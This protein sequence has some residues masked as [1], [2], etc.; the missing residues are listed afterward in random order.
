MALSPLDRPL[1]ELATNDTARYVVPSQT[2]QPHQWAWDSC[3]HAIILAY[4][5]PE[6][7]ARELES[8]LESQWDDGRVPHM[9][10]NPAVPANK[11]RP[12]AEDWGTG[13]PTSGIAAPPL[14]ATAAKVI[15][16]RTGDLEFLKRVYPRIGAYHRWLKGTRD[17]KERG[18]VGIVHPWESAMDDSPAWDG[19]RDEFLR[20]RGGEAAALPR[21]DLRGVPN[22]QRPGDEDHRFYG[23]LI[24]ELQNTGWDG[25]RMAEGSPF[26]V[27][28]VLF[29]SL[30]AKAN[31]DLSQIAWLLGE[32]GDSSQYRFYSS[33]VRQAIRESMW[34]AEARFFFPIDLRRWESIRVKS[35][36]GFLPLYAQAASAP[37]ASLLVE[38][39]SDRRSFHYAV[40][41]PAAAYGEEAFDPGCYRRGPVWMD[42]QW[43]L[44]NGLMRYGCFDLAHG[45]AERA[46]RLVFEQGYWEYYDPFTGQGMGAPHYSA[47]TL[48][49][50]IEPFEPPDELRAGVQVLT[51]E[52]AD[53]HEELAV[54]YRHPEACEDPI[55]I[56][57]IVS[58]PR[59]IARRVLE[60]VRQEVKNALKPAPELSAETLQRMATSLKGVIQ[61]QRGLWAEHPRISDLACV[62]GEAYFRGIGLPV[63][64]LSNKH[65]HRYL[66]LGLPGRP[67]WIVDLTGE[68]FVTHPLARVALLV[69]R[70]TLELERDM[71]G[72]APSWM[73]LEEQF[74]Q[75][76]YAVESCLRRQGT[77]RPDRFE[78]ESLVGVLKRDEACVDRLLRMA[79]P[80]STP[81]LQSYQQWLAGVLVQVSSAPWGPPGARLRRP[82]SRPASGR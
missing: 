74:L 81:T 71:A 14:L 18:L 17:P 30:W 29:N 58:T 7:A 77:E 62:A 40:G 25:R 76:Q 61:S 1:R 9:V 54:L 16:R 49:D 75:T 19:L 64:I 2:H 55:G 60:K 34:D 43:L 82:G 13:R 53:R 45:V 3:F 63:R 27:A 21:I 20:R 80:S 65:L 47:S 22:A 36:A 69:E 28:D 8:L 78:Q 73:R 50:I 46:R 33:L 52:Q 12:N 51:E 67:S 39:L 11:Y 37:M 15:F 41:V 31:E 56:E 59:H 6:S 57:Q 35:A 32:K 72:G 66:V 26:Y 42:V 38:H 79:L 24:Q 68:Q 48:A 10:F 44:V 4:L 23:G 70:L 5:K